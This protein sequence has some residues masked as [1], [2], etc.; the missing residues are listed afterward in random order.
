MI[1]PQWHKSSHSSSN[2]NCVEV[3]GQ[4][5]V[6]QVRD[7]KNRGPELAVSDRAWSQ[8][9]QAIRRGDFNAD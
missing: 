5:K 2:A 1:G 3:R 4:D 6:I 8:F 9:I 7:S